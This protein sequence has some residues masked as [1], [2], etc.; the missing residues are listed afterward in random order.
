MEQLDDS[1]KLSVDKLIH[2]QVIDVKVSQHH[3]E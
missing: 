1:A 2:A 3:Q